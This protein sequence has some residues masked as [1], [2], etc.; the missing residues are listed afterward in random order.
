LEKAVAAAAGDLAVAL[1]IDRQVHGSPAG[2]VDDHELH[3]ERQIDRE[4][5]AV[6]TGAEVGD[7]R[8]D[9]NDDAAPDRRRAHHPTTRRTAAASAVASTT[10]PIAVRSAVSGSFSPAPVK[11][12]TTSR[13]GA[14]T[15]RRAS[16]VTPATLAAD[17][18]SQKTP[19]M[20]RLEYAVRI[21]SSVTDSIAPP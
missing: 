7:R 5:E 17:D 12:Q 13:S 2:P 15:P 21:S 16:F 18:G 9:L 4:P 10:L 8:G 20:A 11:T 1:A 3:P 19:S 14:S 6:V